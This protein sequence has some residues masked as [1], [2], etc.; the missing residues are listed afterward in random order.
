[1]RRQN[2]NRRE[3][4]GVLKKAKLSG[5]GF[6]FHDLRHSSATMLLQ[7]GESIASVSNRFG[8]SK[9]SATLDY[10]AHA[11]PRDDARSAD[12]F[13]K[14]LTQYTARDYESRSRSQSKRALAPAGDNGRSAA[15]AAKF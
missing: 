7:N 14:R 12:A 8:H 10:Y 13:E 9:V 2:F 15:A 6:T 5:M 1:M 11:L 3:W 4:L